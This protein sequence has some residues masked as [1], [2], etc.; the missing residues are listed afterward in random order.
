MNTVTKVQILDKT[1]YMSYRANTL[2]KG[3]NSVILLLAMGKIVGLTELFNFGMATSL[4]EG[5]L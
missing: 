1:V 5:K 4:G 2:G 3:M